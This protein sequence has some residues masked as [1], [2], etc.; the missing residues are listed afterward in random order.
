[1]SDE[2][3]EM[4]AFELGKAVRDAGEPP[5]VSLYRKRYPCGGSANGP[6]P[7]PEECPMHGATCSPFGNPE[8]MTDEELMLA[9][10]LIPKGG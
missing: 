10:D 5:L 2:M 4:N 7:L 9:P 3:A 1:M 8:P 6:T